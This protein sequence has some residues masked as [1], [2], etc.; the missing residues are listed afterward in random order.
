M[1]AELQLEAALAQLGESGEAGGVCE[2][3]GTDETGRSENWR[4][5][6]N[7]AL[8]QPSRRAT[9]HLPC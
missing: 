6:R 8:L 3:G 4:K 1:V 5:W 2:A 9:H 7:S